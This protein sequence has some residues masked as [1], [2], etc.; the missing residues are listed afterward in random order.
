MRVHEVTEVALGTEHFGGTRRHVTVVSLLA[1]VLL[2]SGLSACS[3]GQEAEG[4]IGPPPTENSSMG[5]IGEGP[6]S[7]APQDPSETPDTSDSDELPSAMQPRGW[8]PQKPEGMEVEVLKG[9]FLTLPKGIAAGTGTAMGGP[10]VSIT[11]DLA[12]KDGGAVTARLY[13]DK[14]G[15]APAFASAYVQQLLGAPGVSNVTHTTENWPKA[16]EAQ[17]ITWSVAKPDE[18]QV[19]NG[20]PGNYLMLMGVN[21]SGQLVV[22]EAHGPKELKPGELTFDTALSLRLG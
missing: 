20:Q 5:A 11:V 13:V 15:G 21:P 22:V 12:P 7:V 14:Q 2:A 16:S 9:V 4:Y 10:F 19:A 3:S 6:Q 1:S 18:G 8:K 17:A